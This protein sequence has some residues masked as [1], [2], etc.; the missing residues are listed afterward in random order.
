MAPPQS[1]GGPLQWSPGTPAG[2]ARYASEDNPM[3][4]K[5]RDEAYLYIRR[6]IA[7][8]ELAAGRAISEVLL[9]KKLGISRT[10]IREAIGQ[11]AGEGI[12][13]QSPYRRAVVVKLSSQDITELY[14]LREALEIYA[15]GKATRRVLR[16]ADLESLQTLNDANLTLRDELQRSG[17]AGLDREQ[18]HRFVTYDLAFHTYLLRLAANARL[19]K[20]AN[21]TRVLVQIFAIRRR[22]HTIAELENIHRGHH[23]VVRGIAEQNSPGAMQ[24]ISEHIQRSQ[25]ERLDDLNSW[26][27]EA[28][29][30]QNALG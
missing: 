4:R 13:E 6:K 11:L 28:S 1:T 14:E 3:V 8:G 5:A 18:M 12:L 23:D 21:D 10:P 15:V 19:L 30:R 24:A 25:T 16:P 22:G 7:S 17:K 26:E 20:V 9:A 27:V 29:L 2:I